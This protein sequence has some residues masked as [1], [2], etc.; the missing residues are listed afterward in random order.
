MQIQKFRNVCKTAMW[1]IWPLGTCNSFEPHRRV[2][3]SH[4]KQKLHL[5]PFVTTFS[6]RPWS[7]RTVFITSTAEE[8]KVIYI[9]M[10]IALIS[11]THKNM[12]KMKFYK[13]IYSYKNNKYIGSLSN[14]Q[15]QFYCLHQKCLYSTIS[16]FLNLLIKNHKTL[17]PPKFKIFT[18]QLHLKFCSFMHDL[19][20]WT[21][22]NELYKMSILSCWIFFMFFIQ[23]S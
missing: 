7:P 23:A 4:N 18:Y 21:W 8:K 17:Y 9:L 12:M 20:W 22:V 1:K 10:M 16:F 11:R 15:M 3:T 6:T 5:P 14:L 2:W 19:T 13:N